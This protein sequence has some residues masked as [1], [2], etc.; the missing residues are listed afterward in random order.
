MWSMG[1]SGCSFWFACNLSHCGSFWG[2]SM[3]LVNINGL[4]RP[5]PYVITTT[6]PAGTVVMHLA[7][8]VLKNGTV[9]VQGHIQNEELAWK[10][11]K[12]GGERLERWYA[13]QRE[14]RESQILGLDGLPLTKED[15]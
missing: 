9:E 4:S 1:W 10:I 8:L 14:K 15:V 7:L 11:M 2:V 6:Q 5:K 13:Q 12:A 3:K